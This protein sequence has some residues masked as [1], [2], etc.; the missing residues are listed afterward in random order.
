M[1]TVKAYNVDSGDTTSLALKTNGTTAVTVDSSQ[2][3]GIGTSS[4]STYAK[5]A[6]LSADDNNTIA[7]V[8]SNGLIR[9]KG[10]L[11]S[12]AAGVIEATNTTQSAYAPLFVNGSVL[13]LGTGGSERMRIDSS[14]NVGIGLTPAGTGLLEL[15][16]GTATVAPIELTSGT[17]LTS[18]SAGAIEYDGTNFYAT[19]TIGT[20]EQRGAISVIQQFVLSSNG[21]AFGAAIG[22]FFGSN[23]AVQLAA[24]TTYFIEAY[25]YFLK[26]TAGTATWAALFSSAPT[27]AHATLEYTPVT[28]F[29]TSIIT[30]A[31]VNAE[32]TANAVANIAFAATASLTTAVY[33][34]AKIRLFVTTNAATNLRFNVT[35]S[36]GTMTP[37]AGSWY[38][39]RKVATNSGN[40]VA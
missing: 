40:F 31:M 19:P 37:Q 23:S 2:N 8:A 18:V 27:V 33:H 32:A 13:Q 12:A 16:A 28:G 20:T 26:T 10:Y 3:V 24:T 5:L 36:A 39:V 30:G 9:M 1:S 21:S 29:T 7:L 6:V 14:G 35:Q 4:P 22:N 17:N 11:A 34:V 38:T 15:K 25:C